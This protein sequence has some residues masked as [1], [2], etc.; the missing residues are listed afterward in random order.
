MHKPLVFSLFPTRH[1]AM[2]KNLIKPVE[3]R[4]PE[5]PFGTAPGPKKGLGQ[6]QLQIPNRIPP[7]IGYTLQDQEWLNKRDRDAFWNVAKP[8]K[9]LAK[10]RFGAT[11]ET[12]HETLM[13]PVV[14]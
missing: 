10:L 2:P 13:K 9:P 8:L 7:Q 6:L 1:S 3:N 4:F 5:C 12:G 11:G 14:S